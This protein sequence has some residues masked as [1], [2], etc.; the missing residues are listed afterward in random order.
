MTDVIPPNAIS[1]DRKNFNE[2]F[3]SVLESYTINGRLDSL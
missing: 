1:A 2:W 3:V